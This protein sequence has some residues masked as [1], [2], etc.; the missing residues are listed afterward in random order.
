MATTLLP[1]RKTAH[2]MFKLLLE[3]DKMENR[4][5]DCVFIVWDECTAANKVFI[6]TVDRILREISDTYFP[7]NFDEL[8]LLSQEANARMKSTGVL[9][10]QYF[11]GTLPNFI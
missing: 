1:G 7:A 5:C 9:N 11:G 4:L 6:A 3:E 8:Y 2:S 10:A